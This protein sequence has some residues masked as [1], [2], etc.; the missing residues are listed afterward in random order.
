MDQTIA[1]CGANCGTCDSYPGDC[2]GCRAISGRVWWIRHIGQEV[3]PKYEC[4]ISDK[5]LQHCGQCG[6]LPCG[7]FT[8]LKDPS[9]T[10]EEHR[11]MIA[12]CVALL[13][14]PLNAEENQ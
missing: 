7:L 10:D 2:A 9:M 4:C 1:P 6:D 14:S 13:R 11:R 12:E 5:K 3:C 8:D